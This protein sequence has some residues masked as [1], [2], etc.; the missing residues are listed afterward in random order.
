MNFGYPEI[1]HD[2]QNRN[3]VLFDMNNYSFFSGWMPKVDHNYPIYSP[4]W[5]ARM[6]DGDEF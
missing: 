1:R 2:W 3:T 4:L 5:L 6:L